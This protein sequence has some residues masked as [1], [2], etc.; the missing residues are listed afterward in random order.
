MS[1]DPNRIGLRPRAELLTYVVASQLL[2]FG[3]TGH[4]LSVPHVVEAMEIWLSEN[5]VSIDCIDRAMLANQARDVAEE[6]ARRR[7][8]VL[9]PATVARMFFDNFRVNLQC[10]VAQ[11]IFIACLERIGGR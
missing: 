5:D 4:W 8:I 3:T 6:L 7:E 1:D 10:A 9:D 11:A 2:S